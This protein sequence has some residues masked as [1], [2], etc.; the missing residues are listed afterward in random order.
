MLTPGDVNKNST[1]HHS[2]FVARPGH[3][4]YRLVKQHTGWSFSE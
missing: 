3:Y 4:A 2:A 1:S